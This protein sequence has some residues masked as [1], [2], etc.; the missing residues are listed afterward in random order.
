MP[1]NTPHKFF[2]TPVGPPDI[3][4]IAKKLKAKCSQGFDNISTKLIK[5][6]IE[7]I[8]IPLSHI[9]NLS[10]QN[11]DVPDKM[12]IA[13]IIPIFKS[14][15]QN[16][17][18]NYRPISLLPAFSKIIEKLV[19]SRVVKYFN[20]H[21]LFYKHQYGLRTKHSTIHPILHF[22]NHITNENDISG[23]NITAAIFLDLSKEF[24]TISHNIL[25]KK[26][27]FYG[28]RGVANK[29]FENYLK[30]RKQYLEIYETQSDLL[31]INCGIPQGS[32]LGPILFLIYINDIGNSNKLNLLSFADDTTVYLSGQN[33]THLI[34]DISIELSNIYIWLCANRL[35]LN[36]NKTKYMIFNYT[37][38]Q[39]SHATNLHINNIPLTQVGTNF[40]EQTI[41]FL[42]IYIDEKLSW[43][44][45]IS[46]IC[47][48]MARSIFFTNKV[49]PTS[50]FCT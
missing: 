15:E 40:Q 4:T 11:G 10:F 47:S 33:Y 31:D 29:W 19:A 7:E 24:D 16:K 3:I 12:K 44:R 22:I 30:N 14:G 42:G 2:L 45:H 21:N 37:H 38:S 35:S 26:I 8:S 23:K 13:K 28:I 20:Q 1:K 18:N 32:I 46:Q 36:V 39:N 6:T 34:R 41:K 25:L 9:I 48:K 27:T 49:K 50:N 17:F 5:K 43:K